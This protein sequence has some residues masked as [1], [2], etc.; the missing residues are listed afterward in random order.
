MAQKRK[1]KTNTKGNADAE[2]SEQDSHVS[3]IE[4]QT[5]NIEHKTEICPLCERQLAGVCTKHHLIPVSRGGK[6][7]ETVLLHK[8]CHDKIHSAIS[9]KDLKKLYNT[10]EKL[11][12]HPEL[13][14]FIEWVKKKPPAFYDVSRR[15]KK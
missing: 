12:A 11:R 7:T 14:K 5:S 13:I 8:V 2:Y 15:K 6:H 4:H 1:R 3:D 10:V 9:E